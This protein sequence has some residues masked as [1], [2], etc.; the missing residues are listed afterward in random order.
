MSDAN[1]PREKGVLALIFAGCEGK[2]EIR[3]LP[4]GRHPIHFYA[5][6][7]DAESYA[8]SLDGK[9]DVY[10]GAAT[11]LHKSVT[12]TKADVQE[13]P[14]L[15]ADCD[16]P[17]S[18]AA[19]RTFP[20]RPTLEVESSPGRVHAWWLF[21]EPTSIDGPD[22]VARIEGALR[23]IVDRLG[24]D[25]AVAEIARIMRMPGTKNVKR[26]QPCRLLHSDGPRCDLADF[27][28]LGIFQEHAGG[29]G[30]GHGPA[31]RLD[32]AAVLAGVPEGER[33]NALFRLAC[34]LRGADVP[35][36]AAERLALE[37]AAACNPP[38]PAE[39][40]KA[41]VTRAYFRYPAGTVTVEDTSTTYDPATERWP[42]PPAA[43]AYH[44]PLGEI[45][46]AI[47]PHTEADPAGILAQLLV[48]LG[49]LIGGAPFYRV[50]STEHHINE[51]AALVGRTAGGRKGTSWDQAR[52]RLAVVD[53]V[54]A[55]E[56]VQG[57]LASGEGLI[58]HIRD[59]RE[60]R[61]R[62]K[63]K[64]KVAEYEIVEV[65]AGVEDK[66]L[67]CYE[68]EFARVLRVMAREGCTLST[69]IRQAWDGPI[70]RVMT[71]AAGAVATG[72][73]V[74]IIAHVTSEELLRELQD[75]EAAS[76]FANR[77]LWLAVKRARLLPDG[78]N[79]D[80]A[81][82]APLTLRLRTAVDSARKTR[83][84]TRDAEARK[85]WHQEYPRLTNS[86]RAGLL[87]ALLSRA[88]AHV[89]RLSMIYAL[90][91]SSA[92]IRRP[93]LEAALALWDFTER[94]AG[95]IFGSSLGDPTADEYL[96]AVR[97]ALE[98]M[99]KTDISKHFGKN[100]SAAEL[101]RAG[102]VL[103]RQGLVRWETVKREGPGRPTEVCF[104]V[105]VE[106][107]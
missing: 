62:I 3:P 53:D 101:D 15:W 36:E 19:L 48:G 82:L 21:K 54:W 80:S 49:N 32:T 22:T 37:A 91:D 100:K 45:V 56:R 17:E 11:R 105:Q 93:H 38:F 102:N 5:D 7:D 83:E 13:I 25:P 8:R 99:S 63:N 23:G 46:H 31:E 67:L 87:G 66:R 103:L 35:Q 58:H 14:G 74:S 59:K 81:S 68:P 50:E 9:V 20:L 75:T 30:N 55:R 39:S 10:F 86:D 76:G 84:M 106:G 28:E 94:S 29:R 60:E 92:S 26:G 42:D 44:G 57:G 79:L 41:K 2:I 98:G 71:K 4:P 104:A 70:L 96:R 33:D 16:T 52:G 78:G 65:D 1:S 27:L 69:I 73:H 61:Q 77:F 51:F 97:A 107:R 72:A 90:A 40:A 24:S 64:S 88:E 34:K 12:G 47:E 95:F 18:V 43:A 89:L 6:P 85:L